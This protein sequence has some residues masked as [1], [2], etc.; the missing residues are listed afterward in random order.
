MAGNSDTLE[1][2][3]PVLFDEVDLVS[4]NNSETLTL[5]FVFAERIIV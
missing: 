2:N 3:E 1:Q 5:H 4:L